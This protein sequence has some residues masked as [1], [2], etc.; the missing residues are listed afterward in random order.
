M[1]LWKT[2]LGATILARLQ[3][4]EIRT[5]NSEISI[6]KLKIKKIHIVSKIS[7]YIKLQKSECLT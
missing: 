1:G 4:E 7:I 6:S 3:T 2:T 5:R